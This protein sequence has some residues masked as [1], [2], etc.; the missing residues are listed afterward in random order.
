MR[1]SLPV[2]LAILLNSSTLV[3]AGIL[4]LPNLIQATATD[5]ESSQTTLAQA[6]FTT[7]ANPEPTGSHLDKREARDKAI[8]NKEYAQAQKEKLEGTKIEEAPRPWLRTIYG[9]IPEVVTPTVIGGVTFSTKPPATTDG[10]EPWVTIKKDGTPKT[11]K[12]KLKN[13]QLKNGKPDVKNYF[14]EQST[15]IYSQE[16]LKAH[17]LKPGET[18]EE[19]SW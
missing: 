10:L 4:G 8:V 2:V 12:P 6:T 13:G 18:H 9:T 3:Q 5:P 19:R 1:L 14:K 15:I 16:Q 17:N 7:T 11:I